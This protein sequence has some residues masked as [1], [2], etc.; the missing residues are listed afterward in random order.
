MN[1][2]SSEYQNVFRRYDSIRAGY[3]G[4]SNVDRHLSKISP[5]PQLI[6]LQDINIQINPQWFIQIDTLIITNRYILI[7]EIKSYRGIL[8]FEEDPYTLIQ[9]N[10]EDSFV[11]R[12]P[13]LQARS[14]IEGIK[15]WL[16]RHGFNL[17]VYANIV[18]GFP[19]AQV[20]TAPKLIKLIQAEEVPFRIRELN[21]NYPAV[22]SDENVKL[23][24]NLLKASNDPYMAFPLCEYYRLDPNLIRT[25]V[26][27]RKCGSHLQKQ[28][29][30]TWWCNSCLIIV[31][32]ASVR[33]IED[34]L[35]LMKTTISNE[36][37]RKWLGLK[38]K[39]AANYLLK[40]SKLEAI[41]NSKARKYQF[42]SK[43]SLR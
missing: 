15:E 26:I 6:V 16:N 5:T 23:L 21:K 42:S 43:F 41:G 22:I 1:P 36:E 3:N 40:K 18:L 32:K 34:W 2:T 29:Q 14:Y 9:I 33:A 13:Q 30:A 4:E 10:D 20:R 39:Y 17:P 8:H 35:I 38:D 12:C 7:L 37:C 19:T 25:G 28:S 27:C 11:R 24:A 31:E